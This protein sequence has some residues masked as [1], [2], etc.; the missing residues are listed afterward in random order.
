[1]RTAIY[2]GSFD[3]VTLGHWDLIL[4]AEKLVDRLIVAVL[5]NPGK[6][7]AFDLAERVDFLREL[8]SF[9][10]LLVNYAQK[11]DAQF[12]I[13]GV[14]AFS[15]FESEFQM[16]LMN[17]K[18]SA[19]LETMFLMPKEEFS[20][21]SSRLVREVGGMGGDISGLVPEILVERISARLRDPLECLSSRL[22]IG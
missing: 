16:A 6:T 5:H 18:L 12:I 17:R 1:L 19:D 9:H 2:P 11:M 10:G 8:T 22:G 15:D 7:S 21:V 20:M 13:R 4:R 14:R 3:P